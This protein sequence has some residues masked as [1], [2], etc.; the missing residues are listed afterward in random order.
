MADGA[1]A[2][3]GGYGVGI[4]SLRA[5]EAVMSMANAGVLSSSRFPLAMSRDNLLPDSLQVIDPRFETPRNAT[6]L[7]G[8]MLLLLISASDVQ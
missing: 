1:A 3:F 7:T 2:L 6:L 5:V 8:G 4:V